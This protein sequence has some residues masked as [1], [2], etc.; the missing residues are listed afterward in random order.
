MPKPIKAIDAGKVRRD[1]YTI[2]K[3]VY[4]TEPGIRV[5][6]LLFVPAQ[7]SQKGVVLYL[8]DK[9]MAEA[10]AVGGPIEKLVKEGREVLA[11]DVRGFGETAPANPNARKPNYFGVD[12]NA[13]FIGMHLNRPLLGQRVYDVLTVLDALPPTKTMCI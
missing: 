2:R 3:L 11:L 12:Y 8:S 5:P 13:I 6:A 1:G 10:A 9:G 7:V 4:E